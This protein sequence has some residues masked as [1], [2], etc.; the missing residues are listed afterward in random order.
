M[1][2]PTRAGLKGSKM[3][4]TL[5]PPRWWHKANQMPAFGLAAA[6]MVVAMLS[7]SSL[8]DESGDAPLARQQAVEPAPGAKP[9]TVPPDQSQV[10]IEANEWNLW[11]WEV[12]QGSGRSEYQGL[13]TDHANG[14]GALFVETLGQLVP[15]IG[16]IADQ[17]GWDDWTDYDLEHLDEALANATNRTG[18]HVPEAYQLALVEHVL[19][20]PGLGLHACVSEQFAVNRSLFLAD[21]AQLAQHADERFALLD[22]FANVFAAMIGLS[23]EMRDTVNALMPCFGAH[24]AGLPGIEEY[25]LFGPHATDQPAAPFSEHGD[26]DGD[27]LSN[28]EEY[29]Q[30]RAAHGGLCT[31]AAA[32]TD[33]RNLWSG[34]PELPIA[35]AAAAGLFAALAAL[36]SAMLLRR[37]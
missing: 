12:P 32:A 14:E 28:I 35:H 37:R 33:P 18:A 23:P 36:G 13:L 11:L 29:Q 30:V 2:E 19:S 4:K 16:L 26:L 1:H 31:F 17:A 21:V 27:G 6:A 8:A 25:E 22:L 10:R 5:L 24:A 7:L 3:R 34:N 9:V 20:H 15:S